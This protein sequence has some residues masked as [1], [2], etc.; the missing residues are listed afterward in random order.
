M[1]KSIEE[2]IDKEGH[3]MILHYNDNNNNEQQITIIVTITTI[4]NENK[5]SRAGQNR[6]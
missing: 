2:V 4:T 6:V 1:I 5:Q 3:S